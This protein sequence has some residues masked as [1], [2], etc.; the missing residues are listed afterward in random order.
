MRCKLERRFLQQSTLGR[1]AA[2]SRVIGVDRWP[3]FAVDTV[4]T[5]GSKSSTPLA[6][7]DAEALY[8]LLKCVTTFAEGLMT[9]ISLYINVVEHPARMAMEEPEHIHRQWFESFNRAAKLMP[10]LSFVP[11]A[12]AGVMY[13]LKPDKAGPYVAAAAIT[14]ANVPYSLGVLMP[15]YISPI[16][17]KEICTK[18]DPAWVVAKVEGWTTWHGVRTALHLTSFAICVYALSSREWSRSRPVACASATLPFLCFHSV[19]LLIWGAHIGPVPDVK[20]WLYY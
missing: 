16:Y 14:F 15:N 7:M 8:P 3:K 9:G 19:V 5:V 2:P 4:Q 20:I 12:G 6:D 17:D 13:Y 11:M 18:K 1:V 10:V